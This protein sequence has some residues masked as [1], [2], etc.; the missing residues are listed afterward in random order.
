[1]VRKDDKD[2]TLATRS[3]NAPLMWNDG[4]GSG[5]SGSHPTS[6]HHTPLQTTAPF[7]PISLSQLSGGVSG[8]GGI[9]D[10][11]HLGGGG[12]DPP[13]PTSARSVVTV[14]STA[15]STDHH[16][17][18]GGRGAHQHH[19]SPHHPHIA[20]N[21]SELHGLSLLVAEKVSTKYHPICPL[22]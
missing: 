9:V 16:H 19:H 22:S 20:K 8:G 6:G 1:M 5:G 21:E 7:S 12:S 10:Y 18:T 3:H 4:G 2:A 13:V 11:P 17:G 15:L 14:A